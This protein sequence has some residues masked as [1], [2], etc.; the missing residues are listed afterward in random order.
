MLAELNRIS[1]SLYDLASRLL[2]NPANDFS[3]SVSVS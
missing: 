2:Y 1:N 3:V